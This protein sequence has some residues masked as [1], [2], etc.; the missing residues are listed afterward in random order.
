MAQNGAA[1]QTGALVPR[2]PGGPAP[3]GRRRPSQQAP[4][5]SPREQHGT[6]GGAVALPPIRGGSRTPRRGETEGLL[7]PRDLTQI[8]NFIS[9]NQHIGHQ[10]RRGKLSDRIP[11]SPFRRAEP[12]CDAITG[13]PI[14]QLHPLEPAIDVPLRLQPPVDFHSPPITEPL[15]T[16]SQVER[17]FSFMKGADST[18]GS[19]RRP[20]PA[21]AAEEGREPPQGPVSG[22]RPLRV[23]DYELR[24]FAARRAGRRRQE[25]VAYFCMAALSYTATDFHKAAAHC[26]KCIAIL[27]EISDHAGLAAGHNLAGAARHRSGDYDAA[28][29]HHRKQETLCAHYGKAVALINVGV[30]YGALRDRDAAVEALSDAVDH[31]R[32]TGDMCIESLALGNLGLAHLKQGNL[33]GAQTNLEA[34][35]EICSVAGDHTGAA[36]CLLLL[37]EVYA[38]VHDHKHA[39]FYF[40]NALRVAID[41]GARDIAQ[42]ARVNFGVAIGNEQ[43]KEKCAELAAVMRHAPGPAQLLADPSV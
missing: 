3:A 35:M 28:I 19:P 33:K 24:A 13:L 17:L 25:A 32:Q 38:L 8:R 43:Y 39:Q 12:P 26:D 16:A 7:T 6:G 10:H 14:A 9:T 22:K 2:Q 27:E 1:G 40:A 23:K 21:A 42:V 41:G 34:C 18:A 11:H 5:E 15:S 30:G 31:A 37:G 29:H 36:A 4:G 20:A